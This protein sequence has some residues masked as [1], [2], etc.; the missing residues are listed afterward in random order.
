MCYCET[1]D[2]EILNDIRHEPIPEDA[3]VNGC[4]WRRIC[5]VRGRPFNKID[6][7]TWTE[8]CRKRGYLFRRENPRGF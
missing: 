8:V 2:T 5:Q 3:L 4:C 6:A 1:R 7:D